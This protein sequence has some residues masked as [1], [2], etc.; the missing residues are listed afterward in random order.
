MLAIQGVFFHIAGVGGAS[1]PIVLAGPERGAGAG[2]WTLFIQGVFFHIAGVGAGTTATATTAGVLAGDPP[3]DHGV[4]RHTA[5]VGN[6]T[7]LA[8]EPP[9]DH[10]VSCHSDG[11]GSTANL[12]VGSGALVGLTAGLFLFGAASVS[13]RCKM[14]EILLD[15]A[16]VGA[17]E[18]IWCA[19]L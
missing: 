8:D 14:P 12:G 16:G 13:L 5:G 11:V 6:D 2:G 15:H 17:F 4:S 9:V 18:A 1:S 3:V 10:G 7:V 19:S